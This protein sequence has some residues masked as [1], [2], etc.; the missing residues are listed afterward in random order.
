MACDINALVSKCR[1]TT[2]C[3]VCNSAASFGLT[4]KELEQREYPGSKRAHLTLL[5]T[6]RPCFLRKN[7]AFPEIWKILPMRLGKEGFTQAKVQRW[8]GHWVLRTVNYE[9]RVNNNKLKSEGQGPLLALSML[10]VLDIVVW[11]MGSLM[12]FF[13]Q[14]K[15]R[16]SWI[17]QSMPQIGLNIIKKKEAVFLI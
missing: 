17:L 14:W 15:E 12:P 11:A 16:K 1:L 13:W 3:M 10:N 2:T 5:G 7:G 9:E 4:R 8:R 6:S